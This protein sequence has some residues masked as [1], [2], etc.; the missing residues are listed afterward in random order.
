M[1]VL[2]EQSRVARQAP[3]KLD[4]A[5]GYY[6]FAGSIGQAIGPLLIVVFGGAASIPNTTLLFGAYLVSALLMAALAVVMALTGGAPRAARTGATPSLATA[7]KVAPPA[8]GQLIGAMAVSMMVLAAVDLICVYLPALGVERGLP[9]ALVGVLLTVRAAATMLSRLGLGMLV[10]RVGRQRL[11]A[12]STGASAL[13]VAV[14][15]IPLPAAAMAVLLAAAGVALGIG[16]PLTMTI[17][18][19]TAPPGTRAT[20]L[21]LRLS[22]NRLG[23]SAI[24]ALVGLVAAGAGAAGV[25]ATIGAVLGLTSAA[26]WKTTRRPPHPGGG[27]DGGRC[28]D[29]V[30]DQ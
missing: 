8:R 20:W 9:A 25:F 3:G 30:G 16:Q 6:T 13:L 1:S 19:I 4:S 22:A 29:P 5:F 18:S 28:G 12:L 10:A 21:A 2:G 14:L 15:A 7:L 11:I 17:I 27:R 23:Q 26:S 24:P